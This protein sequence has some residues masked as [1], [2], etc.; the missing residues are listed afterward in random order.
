MQPTLTIPPTVFELAPKQLIIA[1]RDEQLST[2]L[3]T[4]TQRR[5]TSVAFGLYCTVKPC[6]KLGYHYLQQNCLLQVPPGCQACNVGGATFFGVGFSYSRATGTTTATAEQDSELL[7]FLQYND[8]SYRSEA[9]WVV[10]EL[11]ES[12]EQRPTA[13]RNCANLMCMYVY[14]TAILC[15][16]LASELTKIH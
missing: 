14:S 10:F 4:P 3:L 12:N 8:I 1:G 2:T 9:T 6:K 13:I 11:S 16:C 7:L 5:E 15:R